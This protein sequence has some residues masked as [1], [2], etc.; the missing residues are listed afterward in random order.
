MIQIT[1]A[2]LSPREQ[3]AKSS[4]AN[5]PSKPRKPT[6][7]LENKVLSKDESVPHLPDAESSSGGSTTDKV[8][9]FTTSGATT[10][11]GSA[12]GATTGGITGATAG[13]ISANGTKNDSGAQSPATPTNTG[14]TATTFAGVELV[15]VQLRRSASNLD[16]TKKDFR[17]RGRRIVFCCLQEDD[18]EEIMRLREERARRKSEKMKKKQAEG[19]SS[20]G[21]MNY[22]EGDSAP[23]LQGNNNS[24]NMMLQ[25]Q[26]S[27][28]IARMASRSKSSDMLQSQGS[29]EKKSL[30]S[31]LSGR[32]RGQTDLSGL[33]LDDLE[34]N[35]SG[36]K[37]VDVAGSPT[38]SYAVPQELRITNNTS[39]PSAIGGS[40]TPFARNKSPGHL[41]LTKMTSK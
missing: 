7:N 35:L 26:Q 39:T 22:S 4:D 13:T 18:P 6:I 40:Q 24:E 16:S 1:R 3:D 23:I 5:N 32:D 17:R 10:S 36:A 21:T 9:G 25:S 31:D 34:F 2:Q 37:D 28:T 29:G 33:Y 38:S 12:S 15:K 41:V 27:I 30:M 19:E 14:Q 20:K 11:S 8:N